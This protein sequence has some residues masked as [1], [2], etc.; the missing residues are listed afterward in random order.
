MPLASRRKGRLYFCAWVRT[1]CLVNGRKQRNAKILFGGVLVE[2]H[3]RVVALWRPISIFVLRAVAFEQ[4]RGQGGGYLVCW[5]ER[6]NP[7]PHV[8]SF[9]PRL[10]FYVAVNFVLEAALSPMRSS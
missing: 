4:G 9:P 6:G 8:L 1:F 2:R 3:L 5:W 7:L 10:L